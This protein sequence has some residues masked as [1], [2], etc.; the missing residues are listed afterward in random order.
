MTHDIRNQKDKKKGRII[1]KGL[2]KTNRNKT[3][4]LHWNVTFYQR[5]N[6]QYPPTS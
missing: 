5:D 6:V 1:G 3:K 4:S 2:N